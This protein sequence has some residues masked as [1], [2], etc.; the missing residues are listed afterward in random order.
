MG[1]DK[2]A[3][4]RP[5]TQKRKQIGVADVA[6]GGAAR[7]GLPFPGFAAQRRLGVTL[8]Y[9]LMEFGPTGSRGW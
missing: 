3:H 8:P 4:E 5:R 2:E 7:V 1:E 9:A 6:E